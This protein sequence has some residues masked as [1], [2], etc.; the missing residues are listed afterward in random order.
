VGGIE[1][2][3]PGE[4]TFIADSKY[5][6]MLGETKASAVIVSPKVTQADKPLLSVANPSLPLQKS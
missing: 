2:A 1:E 4:I 6:S 5:L 3:Q